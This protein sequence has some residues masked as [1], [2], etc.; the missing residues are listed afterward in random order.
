[1]READDVAGC[2]DT[3]LR[4]LAE[5]ASSFPFESLSMIATASRPRL[6]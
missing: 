1:M 4:W 2:L 6:S 3:L 5:A